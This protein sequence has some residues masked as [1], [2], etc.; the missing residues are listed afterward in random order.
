[1][2]VGTRRAWFAQWYN[3]WGQVDTVASL[4]H[5]PRSASKTGAYTELSEL[6]GLRTFITDLAGHVSAEAARQ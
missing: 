6:A 1:M 4:L 3:N 2:V 5:S